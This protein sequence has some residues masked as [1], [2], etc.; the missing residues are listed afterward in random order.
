M[1]KKKS[2][3]L[4]SYRIRGGAKL[5]SSRRENPEYISILYEK[6]KP[7]LATTRR[8]FIPY[9]WDLVSKVKA[10]RAIVEEEEECRSGVIKTTA[11]YIRPVKWMPELEL[12]WRRLTLEEFCAY[13]GIKVEGE[14]DEGDPN[15]IR[16]C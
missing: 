12:G 13:Y 1:E 16:L 9:E 8:T 4:A 5:I 14:K 2:V 11:K 6:L 3:R 15:A 10:D 7:Y